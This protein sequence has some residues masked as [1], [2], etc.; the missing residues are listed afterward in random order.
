[1]MSDASQ[2]GNGAT[3]A[4]S[5]SRTDLAPPSAA[6]RARMVAKIL[7]FAMVALLAAFL[8]FGVLDGVTWLTNLAKPPLVPVTGKVLFNGEPL[9]K[10]EIATQPLKPGLRGSNAMADE[11]GQFTL[12]TDV[13]GEFVKGA[14]A[15]PHRVTVIR[16]HDVVTFGPAPARTPLQYASFD[17]SPLQITIAKGESIELRLEGEASE[18]PAAMPPM[19]QRPP[20]NTKE[21]APP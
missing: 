3:N 17:T 15:G 21:E 1:M 12:V 2:S 18:P 5:E 13:D 10:A 9:S 14:Y 8:F 7:A 20:S 11:A 16:R 4:N 19:I 6:F